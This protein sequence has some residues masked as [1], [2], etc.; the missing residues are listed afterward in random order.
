ML[1]IWYVEIELDI[2]GA[3]AREYDGLHIVRGMQRPVIG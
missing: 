2:Q 1:G 3:N